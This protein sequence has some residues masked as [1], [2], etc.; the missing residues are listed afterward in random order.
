[1]IAAPSRVNAT[2]VLIA[3]NVIAYLWCSF[4]GASFIS[5]FPDNQSLVDHGAL[6]GP[7]VAQGQ[8]WRIISSGFLHEGLLH[9]GLNMFALYQVGTLVEYLMG[10]RRMLLVYFIAMI[11]SGLA[12]VW[13]SFNQPTLGASGA[14]FGLF[15]ALVAIGLQLGQRGRSLIMQVLPIIGINLVFGFSVPGISNAAH[16][17]G[18]LSGFVAG[19]I[20]FMTVPRQIVAADSINE[21]AVNAEHE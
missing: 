11:G 10:A 3:L 20:V 17:G 18:L 21:P 13:F 5:G 8:W 15:G 1:M 7:F 19:L 12:V 6:Y 9:I 4:T 2:R 14:I 16:I